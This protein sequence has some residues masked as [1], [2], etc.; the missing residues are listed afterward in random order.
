MK[1]V[2]VRPYTR[3]YTTPHLP[4]VPD[5]TLG[6]RDKH[7]TVFVDGRKV[8]TLPTPAEAARFAAREARQHPER[9]IALGAL[10]L[11]APLVAAVEAGAVTAA[12]VATAAALLSTNAVGPAAV[13]AQELIHRKFFETD[14][15]IKKAD[16]ELAKARESL[17]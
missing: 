15:E 10:I 7:L 11:T 8:R 2:H 5:L 9:V 3:V 1:P 13:G 16:E 14:E 12:Q 4:G 17:K 6:T